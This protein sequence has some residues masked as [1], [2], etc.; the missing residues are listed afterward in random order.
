MRI[1]FSNNLWVCLLILFISQ[2]VS[3]EK[4]IVKPTK[5]T[6][7]ITWDIIEDGTLHINGYGEMP[8]FKFDKLEHWRKKK[9]FPSMIK[10]IEV[11][12]GITKIG[13]SA[14]FYLSYIH[15][16]PLHDIPIT[17]PSTL[18][19][20]GMWGLANLVLPQEGLP[21]NLKII[22]ANA[23]E[24]SKFFDDIAIIPASVES[25]SS[26]CFEDTNVK[27]IIIEGA[28]TIHE[29]TFTS[30]VKKYDY[31]N[32]DDATYRKM[33][34][35]TVTFKNPAID[36]TKLSLTHFWNNEEITLNVAANTAIPKDL[37]SNYTVVSPEIIAVKEAD[38]NVKGY[39]KNRLGSWQEFLS[40]KTLP[41]IPTEAAAKT[42]IEKTMAAWQRKG[43]YE[44][45]AEWKSRVN[46]TSRKQK[47]ASLT[48]EWN[49]KVKT[50]KSEYN[51]SLERYRKEYQKEFETIQRR[52]YVELARNAIEEYQQDNYKITSPYDADNETFLISS[53]NHGDFLLM[54]PRSEAEDFRHYWTLQKVKLDF[55]FVPVSE[56]E[57]GL[58]SIKFA[59]PMKEY[60]YDGKSEAKYAVADIDYN[61]TPLEVTGLRFDGLSI[62]D[63]ADAPDLAQTVTSKGIET[64][65]V[66]PER[67]SLKA[68]PNGSSSSGNQNP[69]QNV[70]MPEV[71]KNIPY[72]SSDRKNTFA[73]IIANENYK[74]VTPVDYATNDGNIFRQY[75][76][77]TLRVPEKN[78]MY[79]SDGSLNDMR[80]IVRRMSDICNTFDGEASVIVYYAGHGVPD[81][82]TADAYL[83]PV[84]GY[85]EDINTGLSLKEFV[86]TLSELPTKQ[87]TMFVDACFSGSGRDGNPLYSARGVALKPKPISP[88]GNLVMFSASQGVESAMPYHEMGHGLFT[89]YLLD[90]LKASKGNVTL[91]ELSEYL[92]E[93]VKRT[94]VVE[95]K[96]QTPTVQSSPM[97]PDWQSKTL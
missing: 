29:N 78:I 96:L 12:E 6:P 80:H 73:L 53:G 27:E 11:G 31:K 47:L 84:D 40:K 69:R 66:E 51:A 4:Y 85:A 22:G 24:N 88:K 67:S 93:N 16:T 14:F 61:F 70:S 3:A 50:A 59:T 76:T 20:I 57:V 44:S 8:D 94:S 7:T 32:E 54:V 21:Q 95:G 26:G 5:L 37:P 90:K 62:P 60:K 79:L 34:Q 1:R 18:E 23:F 43:E 64:R 48:K 71:D 46:D 49:D 81:E 35:Y 86:N 25:M 97:L 75:V 82:A 68:S 72:G 63:L 92:I 74:R 39:V 52:F 83:L 58:S 55:G 17:L 56:T 30:V 13:S 33:H 2:N 28:P 65:R 42:D 87:I 9:Y 41:K 38:K 91:G 15:K 10:R 36:L 89:Y 19:N 77:K 45:T